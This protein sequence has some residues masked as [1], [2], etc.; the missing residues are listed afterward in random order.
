MCVKGHVYVDANLVNSTVYIVA[1]GEMEENKRKS[2]SL[3]AMR[4]FFISLM[5]TEK[6]RK[7]FTIVSET[8]N[9]VTGRLHDCT[10]CWAR[11]LALTKL[12]HT[13]RYREGFKPRLNQEELRKRFRGSGLRKRHGRP[14]GRLG[15]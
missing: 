10:Y 8:W 4:R 5:N 9:P 14:V 3:D 11:H 7:M 15:A 13:P 6:G 1:Q 12:R 2:E